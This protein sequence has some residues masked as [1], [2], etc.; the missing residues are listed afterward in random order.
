MRL[1]DVLSKNELRTLREADNA[2]VPAGGRKITGGA[3]VPAN[4]ANDPRSGEFLGGSSTNPSGNQSN[5]QY[6]VP[7][8]QNPNGINP[9][10]WFKPQNP[11][12]VK[13]NQTPPPGQTTQAGPTGATPPPG[14]TTQAGP[15]G[16]T[17]TPN[18]PTGITGPAGTT[19]PPPGQT[20]QPATTTA[21]NSAAGLNMPKSGIMSKAVGKIATGL[22]K[23]V[24]G[25]QGA[26]QGAK[27]AF[28][29]GQ[30]AA[31]AAATRNVAQAGGMSPGQIRS[32]LNTPKGSAT[33]GGTAPSAS[34]TRGA[35]GTAGIGSG[36][37]GSGA[38]GAASAGG[39]ST[40]TRTAGTSGPAGRSPFPN[41]VGQDFDS[42]HNVP[43]TAA[44][45]AKW[46]A[47]KTKTQQNLDW[48]TQKETAATRAGYLPNK[49]TGVWT[50]PAASG[51]QPTAESVEDIIRLAKQLAAR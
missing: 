17:T 28:N 25:V 31:S 23:A 43:V 45:A 49:N 34:G 21:A 32:A 47:E 14:Q 19:P 44:G 7:N 11:N 1:T 5:M 36:G 38:A 35:A 40:N 50:A 12:A 26:A 8:T 16:A 41:L 15:T 39:A 6:Q 33:P 46:N 29:R 13:I 18:T 9:A 37:R 3:I 22:G 2:L 4:K 10:N 27:L 30:S 48:F 24:G 42:T 20:T 51:T